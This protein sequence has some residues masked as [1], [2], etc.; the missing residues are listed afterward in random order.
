MAT[1][2]HVVASWWVYA[3]SEQEA[4]DAVENAVAASS[5]ETELDDSEVDDTEEV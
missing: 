3:D 2:F 4:I 5:T 1:K